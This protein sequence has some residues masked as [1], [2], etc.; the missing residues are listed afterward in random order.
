VATRGQLTKER[1]VK[2]KSKTVVNKRVTRHHQMAIS[3]MRTKYRLVTFEYEA[4][5]QSEDKSCNE[6]EILVVTFYCTAAIVWIVCCVCVFLL[7]LSCLLC[8][9]QMPA[10]I[11]SNNPQDIT[12][13]LFAFRLHLLSII[14]EIRVFLSSEMYVL[15]KR[16]CTA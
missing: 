14:L 16:V 3:R 7:G 4:D 12:L 6:E 2:E 15:E 5:V 9:L 1:W 11:P 13:N 10:I 8:I